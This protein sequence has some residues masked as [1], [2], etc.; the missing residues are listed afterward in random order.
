MSHVNDVAKLQVD[1]ATINDAG[2]YRCEAVNKLGR[3]DTDCKVI[4]KCV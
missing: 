1:D 3:V 4:V 2:T